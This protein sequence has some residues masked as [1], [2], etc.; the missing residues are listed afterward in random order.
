MVSSSD[1]STTEQEGSLSDRDVWWPGT[2]V[3]N[4]EK[5]RIIRYRRRV[6]YGSECYQRVRDAALDWEFHN[7][8]KSMSSTNTSANSI[9]S[10]PGSKGVQMGI[11]R[12]APPAPVPLGEHES[13]HSNIGNPFAPLPDSLHSHVRQVWSFP[14]RRP[15]ATYTQKTLNLSTFFNPVRRFVPKK[16]Q[17]CLSS[18]NPSIYA[19]NPVSVVYDVMD[20]R[21]QGATYTSTAYGTLRGHWLCGEERVTVLLRDSPQNQSENIEGLNRKSIRNERVVDASYGRKTKLQPVS[22][23]HSFLPDYGRDQPVDVEILSYSRAAPSI[24]GRLVWPFI[25]KMQDSFFQS[26]LNALERSANTSTH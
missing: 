5:W 26:E 23:D 6:G 19:V 17:R 13:S 10:I 9:N 18:L 8:D 25:G 14:G 24:M 15:L 12:L 4:T 11:L 20:Q 21:G 7:K 2:R 22:C 1:V 16:I 3:K